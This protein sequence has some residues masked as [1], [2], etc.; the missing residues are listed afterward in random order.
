M[1]AVDEVS[2]NVVLAVMAAPLIAGIVDV[3][4][5]SGPP[6]IN[7]GM[8]PALVAELLGAALGI[9]AWWTH[10]V[11]YAG[12]PAAA[13]LATYLASGFGLGVGAVGL[14]AQYKAGTTRDSERA[15]DRRRKVPRAGS[16]ERRSRPR[17]GREKR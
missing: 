17:N 5:N 14:H 6:W 9:L 4:K 1:I 13:P 8:M 2:Q 7:R 12:A 10:G 16:E 15:A 11:L 3:M